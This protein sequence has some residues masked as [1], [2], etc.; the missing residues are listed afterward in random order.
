MFVIILK[1]IMP[2]EKVDALLPEH[3]EFLNGCYKK[4]ELICSGKRNPRTGG[5]ILA[6]VGSEERVW[7]LIKQDPFFIHKIAE[8]EVIEFIPSK[9]DDRFACFLEKK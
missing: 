4:S 7:E 8:Y 6:N 2:L 9:F 3:I 5:V 1:Y